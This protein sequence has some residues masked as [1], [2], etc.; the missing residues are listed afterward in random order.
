MNTHG[1]EREKTLYKTIR[2]SVRWFVGLQK[3]SVLKESWCCLWD[4]PKSFLPALE[5]VGKQHVGLES[6]QRNFWS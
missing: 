4:W 3:V 1:Q 5:S 2:W 6:G